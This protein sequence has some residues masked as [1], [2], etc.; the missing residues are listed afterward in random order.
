MFI[1]DGGMPA[2]MLVD[3]SL[4]ATFSFSYLNDLL[5]IWLVEVY[6]VAGQLVNKEKY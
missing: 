4:A 6:S 3:A 1:L 2:V 5:E